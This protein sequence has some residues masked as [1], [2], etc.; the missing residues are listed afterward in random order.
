M[1]TNL[2]VVTLLPFA[3]QR[4]E[5]GVFTRGVFVGPLT[6]TAILFRYHMIQRKDPLPTCVICIYV[7]IYTYVY[8]HLYCTQIHVNITGRFREYLPIYQSCCIFK[9]AVV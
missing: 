5:E 4:L 3:F 2:F 6:K 1:P 7:C 9:R 8:I